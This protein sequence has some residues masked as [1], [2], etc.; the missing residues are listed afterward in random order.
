MDMLSIIN[1]LDALTPER[2]QELTQRWKSHT[3]TAEDREEL[4]TH[5]AM[6]IVKLQDQKLAQEITKAMWS[7]S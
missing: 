6:V 7:E 5:V 1:R 2:R 3:M 4:K